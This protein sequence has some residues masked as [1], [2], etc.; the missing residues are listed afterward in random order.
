MPKNFTNGEL[1]LALSY[2]D[3][4]LVPQYSDIQTRKMIDITTRLSKNIKLNIPVV[5]ANMDTVTEARMATA[6]ALEGG[7]GIIH[8]FMSIEEQA[9]QV[10]KVKRAENIFISDPITIPQ[11]ATLGEA[12]EVMKQNGVNGIIVADAK[13]NLH[14]MLT[15]RDVRFKTDPALKVKELMTPRS[16]LIIASK[17]ITADAAMKLLD[18]HKLEKLPL[19]DKA[20][21][22]AGLVT[23][24][25]FKKMREHA[26]AAKDKEGQLLVG[27]AVGVK[28]G[29]ER[30]KALV[31]AGCDVLVID[32]A[33]GHHI[34]CVELLKELKKKFVGVDVVAGNVA[35]AR[36]TEDL[37]K[38]G[39][40]AVKVGI[41]PG[42]ACSTRIVA[43]SG[44]PQFT[45]VKACVEAAKKYN[46]PVIADGGIKNSGDVAKAVGA[47]AATVMIGNMFAGSLESP[48]EY[49]IEDGGAFKIYRG[50]ASRDASMDRGAREANAER[51]DRAPEGIG[52]RVTYK[53]EVKRIFG[54]LVD[55]LQSG[56]SY[57]GARNLREFSEKAEFVRMTDAGMRESVPRSHQQ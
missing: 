10:K 29:V 9:A 4:L 11:T 28:D 51:T 7:I 35:T 56:M 22:L 20:G 48:G 30:G 34:R 8:R 15:A 55:G 41:G 37:I 43:G 6:M 47:G 12:L 44:V 53:G 50:L 25:D 24:A 57:T 26:R 16:K 40:D 17:G 13:K 19:V 14:G 46:I 38:V 33:H 27:A 45:A 31:E 2:D 32:I 23:A 18:K 21:K 54:N 36:G 42:A 3:V 39:A 49:Y 1:S 5:S 52:Y